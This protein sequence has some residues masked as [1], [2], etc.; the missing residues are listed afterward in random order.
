[1]LNNLKNEEKKPMS[2]K[3]LL[4]AGGCVCSTAL[5][6]AASYMCGMHHAY[7]IQALGIQEMWDADSTLKDH[8]WSVVEKLGKN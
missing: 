6:L 8:M 1:M 2:K 4:F 3:E 7:R 5:I